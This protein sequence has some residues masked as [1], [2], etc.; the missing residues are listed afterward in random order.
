MDRLIFSFV[1]QIIH[2]ILLSTT[3]QKLAKSA[4]DSQ[5]PRIQICIFKSAVVIN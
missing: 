4:T 5:M 3:C 2:L 1:Y